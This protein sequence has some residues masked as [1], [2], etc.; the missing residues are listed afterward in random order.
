MI[1]TLLP[2]FAL[3][4]LL[5]CTDNVD[6]IDSSTQNI[7]TEIEQSKS[8]HWIKNKHCHIVK[9]YADTITFVVI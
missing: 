8:N 4:A 5:G 1:K 2:T 7:S 6:N 3:L 9:H